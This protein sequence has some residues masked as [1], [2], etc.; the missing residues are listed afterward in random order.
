MKSKQEFIAD[1][2][3]YGYD[4]EGVARVD[5]KVVFLPFALLGETILGRIEDERSSFCRGKL[6]EVKEKSK[7]REIPPCPYFA[8]CGGCAY[9]HTSY[10]NELEV[11]KN[12]LISQLKKAGIE[13]E[14][15]V[16]CSPFEYGYRNKIRMFVGEQGLSLKER[17]SGRLCAVEKCLLVSDEIN[18]AIEI[19]NSFILAR[20]LQKVYKEVV[21]R[22]E[23]QSLIVNFVLSYKKSKIDY[24]GLFLRLGKNFGIY[25]SFNGQ[26][27]HKI[28][29][30]VLYSEEFGLKCNFAPNSFHQVNRFLTSHLYE[31]AIASLVG[32]NVVNCYSG[33]GVLSGVVAGSGKRVIGIE[34]GESEHKDAEKLKEENSLFY[35][36]NLNGDCADLLPKIEEKI[37]SIIVDPPRS[38]MD[39]KVVETLNSIDFERLVYISCNSA[40]LVRDLS[41]LEGVKIEKICLFDMFARTGEYEIF[42]VMEKI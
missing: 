38:G 1:I 28:G 36:T 40:T 2:S 29:L 3:G 8:K 5:G 20:K 11:K 15:E 9:Q 13:K 27:F 17:A 24:Q 41:R 21:I 37:D 31:K 25:E 22:Q 30:K 33:A 10:Q 18:R 23:R 26:Y 14:V 39:K 32:K 16:V 34:L 19:V 35:L 7:F 12:L 6:L 42:V 4:G